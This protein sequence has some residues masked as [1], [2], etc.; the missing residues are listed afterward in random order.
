MYKDYSTLIDNNIEVYGV[1][2][3]AFVINT[4]DVEKARKVIKFSKDIGGWRAENNKQVACPSDYY[5]MKANEIPTIPVF[6]NERIPTPDEYDTKSICESVV[7]QNPVLIKAKYAG[8]GKSYIG[9]YMKHLGYNVLFVV[10]NNKQ[11]QEVK[12]EAVTY[13]KFF[14]IAVE[15]GESLPYFDHGD[16]NCIVFDELGQVRDMS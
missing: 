12:C 7:K 3:N 2:T 6:K 13:N 8:S 11:L 5:K 16:F 15:A 14:S 4:A 1:K 9:E 10:P